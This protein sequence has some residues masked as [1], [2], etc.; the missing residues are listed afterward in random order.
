MTAGT[1]VLEA[2]ATATVRDGGTR[3]ADRLLALGTEAADQVRVDP[4]RLSRLLG[5]APSG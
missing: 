5:W 2:R 1:P 3:G 4:T